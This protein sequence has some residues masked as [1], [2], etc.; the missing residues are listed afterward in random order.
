MLFGLSFKSVGGEGLDF[1]LVGCFTMCS[2]FMCFWRFTNREVQ[3]EFTSCDAKFYAEAS[4]GPD[5]AEIA[6]DVIASW[7]RC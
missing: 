4:A 6:N 5:A 7:P 2:A 3:E 1:I